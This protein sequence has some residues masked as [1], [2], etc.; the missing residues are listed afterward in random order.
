MELKDYFEFLCDLLAINN[1]KVHLHNK[2][3]FFDI[4]GH[5]CKPFKLKETSIA[6]SYPQKNLICIDLDRVDSILIYAILAHEVRHIYQYQA[7]Q[8]PSW[9]E[10]MASV[11]ELEFAE[12]QGSDVKDYENQ[13]S[14]IDALAFSKLIF[15]FIFRKD[16]E[17]NCNQEL[18]QSRLQYLCTEFTRDEI[19]ECFE[20]NVGDFT[21]YDA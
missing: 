21:N 14:E 8:N 2:G 20:Y 17:V 5:K 16:F 12:Y 7:I 13:S 6:T 11:W 4:K 3:V 19:I 10:P 9:G 18:L 1:P 15:N